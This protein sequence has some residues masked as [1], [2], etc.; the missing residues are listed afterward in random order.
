MK[1]TL[2]RRRFSARRHEKDSGAS[3]LPLSVKHSRAGM[4]CHCPLHSSGADLNVLMGSGA[5][6][7]RQWGTSPPGAPCGQGPWASCAFLAVH[8]R[9]LVWLSALNFLTHQYWSS[10]ARRAAHFWS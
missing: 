8:G 4:S 1:G 6:L 7:D 3:S 9:I 5:R 10:E 2:P